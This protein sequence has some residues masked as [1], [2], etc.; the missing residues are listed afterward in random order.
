M[1]IPLS[2]YKTIFSQPGLAGRGDDGFEMDDL[3]KAELRKRW[4]AA[5]LT[6]DPENPTPEDSERFVQFLSSQ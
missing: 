6:S 1:E 2:E 3:E 5:G 4:N